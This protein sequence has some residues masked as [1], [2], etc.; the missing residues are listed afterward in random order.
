LINKIVLVYFFI[1][2]VVVKGQ[3]NGGGCD[4]LGYGEIAGFVAEHFSGK[5]LQVYGSKIG[6]AADAT[7]AS[8]SFSVIS[9]LEREIFITWSLLYFYYFITLS[10]VATVIWNKLF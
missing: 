8:I 9:G 7:T 5:G 6:S 2:E 4:A 3:G 10:F 1:G